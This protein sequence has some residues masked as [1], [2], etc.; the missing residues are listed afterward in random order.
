MAATRPDICAEPMLRA[1]R[2][3]M[4]SESTLTGAFDCGPAG[5]GVCAEAVKEAASV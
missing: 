5:R 2:P 3:E 4:V 1:P